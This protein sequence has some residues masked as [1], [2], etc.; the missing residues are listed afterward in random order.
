MYSELLRIMRRSSAALAAPLIRVRD[1]N[2]NKSDALLFR[3][4]FGEIIDENKF[5]ARVQ[6]ENTGEQNTDTLY[7]REAMDSSLFF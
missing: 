1:F 5:T 2:L 3:F 6:Y 4:F 7:P